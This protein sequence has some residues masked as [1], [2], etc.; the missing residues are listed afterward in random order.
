MSQVCTK[1]VETE[2]GVAATYPGNYT[3]Y[4]NTKVRQYRQYISTAVQQCG[5]TGSIDECTAVQHH[6]STA[7]AAVHS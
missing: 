5:S 2:R 3:Q 7:C 1:I 4:V 6:V